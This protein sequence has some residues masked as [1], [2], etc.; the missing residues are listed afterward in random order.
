MV[1]GRFQDFAVEKMIS[2]YQYL[3]LDPHGFSKDYTHDIALL[4]LRGKVTL[5]R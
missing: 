4:K 5:N 1:P 3:E 2:H